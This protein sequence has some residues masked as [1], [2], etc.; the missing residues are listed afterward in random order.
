MGT[1]IQRPTRPRRRGRPMR[2][3][4]TDLGGTFCLSALSKRTRPTL[5]RA[6]AGSKQR[7][8][9]AR[10]CQRGPFSTFRRTRP[11]R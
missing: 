1:P 11:R 4:R 8:S 9:V 3:P 5:G 6:L 10:L 2:G 7:I